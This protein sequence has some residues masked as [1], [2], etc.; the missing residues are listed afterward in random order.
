[1]SIKRYFCE[2]KL[3]RKDMAIWKRKASKQKSHIPLHI[4]PSIHQPHIICPCIL[5]HFDIGGWPVKYWRRTMALRHFLKVQF[6][7]LLNILIK[8]AQHMTL[9]V[10]NQ[11]QEYFDLYIIDDEEELFS[12]FDFICDGWCDYDD[13]LDKAKIEEVIMEYLNAEFTCQRAGEEGDVLYVSIDKRVEGLDCSPRQID[14]HIGY[15][16]QQPAT[17]CSCRSE[18]LHHVFAYVM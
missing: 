18:E 17:W 5:C 11:C 4:S 15:L 6:S 10:T 8:S 12:R 1:M 7:T 2:S 14:S 9:A 3:F 16:R 13:T